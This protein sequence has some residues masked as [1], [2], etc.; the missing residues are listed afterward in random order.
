MRRK[1]KVCFT[2]S[3]DTTDPLVCGLEENLKNLEK[4]EKMTYVFYKSTRILL[5][6]LLNCPEINHPDIFPNLLYYKGICQDCS[7]DE[8]T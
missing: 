6:D 3:I 5:S 2:V 1:L 7:P 8:E 4:N